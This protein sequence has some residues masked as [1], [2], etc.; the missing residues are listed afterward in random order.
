MPDSVNLYVFPLRRLVGAILVLSFMTFFGLIPFVV[1]VFRDYASAGIKDDDLPI[2]VL[3]C[4][5]T[6]V[7]F[8]TLY[9]LAFRQWIKF[10]RPIA[11]DTD[12]VSD[13]LFKKIRRHLRW[14]DITI[15]YHKHK[16]LQYSE[17]DHFFLVGSGTE[18]IASSALVK[19]GELLNLI[20]GYAEKHGI[21]IIRT[22]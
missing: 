18:I 9:T 17:V 10:Q 2:A 4:T 6:A 13:Y 16:K 1:A 5:G 20:R 8:A 22:T 14:T 3:F 7:L 15:I 11:I 19:G 12:G 21:R